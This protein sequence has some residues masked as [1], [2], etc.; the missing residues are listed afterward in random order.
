VAHRPEPSTPIDQQAV[1]VNAQHAALDL[2]GAADHQA[3]TR[4]DAAHPLKATARHT[5]LSPTWTAPTLTL[6]PRV[7]GIRQPPPVTARPG[8]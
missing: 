1:A 3:V 2:V 8:S 5:T 4:A 6:P 7:R